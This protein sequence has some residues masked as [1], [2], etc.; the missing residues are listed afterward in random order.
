MIANRQRNDY[1]KIRKG[2]VDHA[3]GALCLGAC[4]WGKVIR[5]EIRGQGLV[6][7]S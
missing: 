7:K 6:K 5:D 4:P 2:R 3:F 1:D